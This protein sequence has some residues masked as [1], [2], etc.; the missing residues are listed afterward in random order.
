MVCHLSRKGVNRNE[1]L[2]LLLQLADFVTSHAEV[3]IETLGRIQH[4]YEAS[5]HLS[6]RGV[7]RNY[8]GS[9]DRPARIVT[10][11]A[12]VGIETAPR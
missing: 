5:R 11:R 3:G 6:R 4:E 8:T 1:L 7:N 10:S 9:T 2:P 12:E